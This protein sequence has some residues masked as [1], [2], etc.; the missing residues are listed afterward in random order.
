MPRSDGQYFTY[1]PNVS[2]SNAAI[3][4]DSSL[5][6]NVRIYLLA[7]SVI[8]CRLLIPSYVLPFEKLVWHVRLI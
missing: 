7:I 3:N 5:V 1:M 6:G 4:L 8:S 2:A